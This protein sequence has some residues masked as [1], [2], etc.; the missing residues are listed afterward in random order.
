LVTDR[1][2]VAFGEYLP[3]RSEA[4]FQEWRDQEA[5]TERKYAM[6]ERGERMPSQLRSDKDSVR[7]SPV[8]RTDR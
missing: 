1:L 6:W 7:H 2:T 4:D 5:W 8:L 3:K